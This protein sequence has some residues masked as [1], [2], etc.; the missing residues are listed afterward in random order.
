MKQIAAAAA[1]AV[2]LGGCSVYRDATSARID[3]G[4][5]WRALATDSDRDSLRTWR[6]AWDE[7]LPEAKTADAG[8]I[9]ADPL[10]FD[11]DRALTDPLPPAGKYRCRTYKMG[12]AGTATSSFIAYPWLECSITDEGEVK[13]LHKLTGSQRPTGLLFPDTK[14]RAIFLGTLILGDETA[15]LRYGIDNDRDMIGYIEQIE[16]K[17][18]RLVMPYP[19][20]ES[21]LDVIELVPAS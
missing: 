11:P 14:A 8:A 12:K 21:K 13:G 5:N 9:A 3:T 2:T 19:R 15:P 4:A 20:F 6:Q 18:W 16:A 10:L 1:L 7:A 17:R